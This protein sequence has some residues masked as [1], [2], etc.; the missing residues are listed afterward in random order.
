MSNIE[1]TFDFRTFSEMTSDE[2]DQYAKL[3]ALYCLNR[4]VFADNIG[5]LASVDPRD[6][7][8]RIPYIRALY[9]DSTLVQDYTN[10]TQEIKTKVRNEQGEIKPLLLQR[11]ATI[12]HIPIIKPIIRSIVAKFGR[13]PWNP[14]A[15]TVDK[16]SVSDKTNAIYDEAINV[17]ERKRIMRLNSLMSQQSLLEIQGELAQEMGNKIQEIRASGD[18]TTSAVLNDQY[19]ELKA[20]HDSITQ[21]LVELGKVLQ[22]KIEL[23]QD[24][25]AFIRDQRMKGPYQMQERNALLLLN[26]YHQ[27]MGLEELLRHGFEE[28]LIHDEQVFYVDWQPGM[29]FVETKLV[30]PENFDYDCPESLSKIEESAITMERQVLSIPSF[31]E[32]YQPEIDQLRRVKQVA[33][34]NADNRF[35]DNEYILPNGQFINYKTDEMR[36]YMGTVEVY[37]VVMRFEEAINFKLVPNKNPGL[38][39]DQKRP[40]FMKRISAAEARDFTTNPKKFKKGEELVKRYRIVRYD[41][42]FIKNNGAYECVKHG[43]APYQHYEVDSGNVL[44]PYIGKPNTKYLPSFSITWETRNL[45]HMYNVL[46]YQQ[47]LTIALAGVRGMIYD[48][49][50]KP[51][52]FTIREVMHFMKQGLMLIQTKDGNGKQISNFNQFATY[53]QSMSQ[54]MGLIAEA[55]ER[56]HQH[57]YFIT[58]TNPQMMAQIQQTDQVGTFRD[59]VA[60]SGDN[61]GAYFQEYENITQRVLT[62]LVNLGREAHKNGLSGQYILGKDRQSLL[63]IPA[64]GQPGSLEGYFQVLIESAEKTIKILESTKA[65]A[66]NAWAK[67]TIEGSDYILMQMSSNTQTLVDQ[68]KQ[69]E[70]KVREWQMQMEKMKQEDP[71]AKVIAEMKKYEIDSR[72]QVEQMKLQV[73]Q[74]LEQ[75]NASLKQQELA[76]TERIES[77]K[78]QTDM[79]IKGED[80]RIKADKVNKEYEVEMAYLNKE[81]FEAKSND[82]NQKLGILV[83]KARSVIEAKNTASKKEKVKD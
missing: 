71:A 29:P 66:A 11:P 24:E 80:L 58:S 8:Y 41:A 63:N 73:Q 69:S 33:A 82:Q 14:I 2:R 36:S 34:M 6:K 40:A 17:M 79:Q 38:W 23:S 60:L 26:Y 49:S 7:K 9:S 74:Q 65:V 10:I 16:Q 68:L 12:K 27:H 70:E 20:V 50:Q 55:M 35:N 77:A 32:K 57:I 5:K 15:Y 25:L 4:A 18:M 67:G 75:M 39:Q 56:V 42:V 31:I 54:S 76:Q 53:D 19:K 61:M 21:E 45:T 44:N 72:S 30:Y 64:K 1:Q 37:K 59:A 22:S 47:E 43:P 28:K 3:T 62:R 46:F 83:N 48:I 81:E 13:L 78:I 52:G 51:S